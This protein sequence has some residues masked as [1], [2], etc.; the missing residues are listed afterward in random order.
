MIDNVLNNIDNDKVVEKVK[1]QS[2]M[3]MHG[4]PLNKW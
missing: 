2:H 1:D 3:M 4:L